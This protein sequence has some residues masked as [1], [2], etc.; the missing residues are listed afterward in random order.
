MMI[1]YIVGRLIIV[2]RREN[3]KEKVP[4]PAAAAVDHRAGRPG[5]AGG[6]RVR[7]HLL[8]EGI[9]HR[10]NPRRAQL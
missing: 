9:H 2:L 8:P 4:H 6:L 7:A 10:R 1:L 5:R 3:E